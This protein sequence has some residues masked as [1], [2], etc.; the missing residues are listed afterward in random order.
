M[1]YIVLIIISICLLCLYIW[2][3]R[4]YGV[5]CQV[6]CARSSHKATTVTGG[7]FIFYLAAMTACIVMPSDYTWLACALTVAAVVSFADDMRP[8]PILIRLFAQLTAAWLL[9]CQLH[10]TS[11]WWLAASLIVM[12]VAYMNAYNFMDGINGITT[13]YTAIVLL[14]LMWL[15]GIYHFMDSTIAWI[16]LTALACFALFNVRKRALCFPGDVG[17]ISLAVITFFMII[18]LIKTTGEIW[19]MVL[20]GVYGVDTAL[21]VA[22]RAMLHEKIYMPHR[23]HLYQMLCNESGLPHIAISSLYAAVQ[24]TVNAGAIL[25][26][27]N[28]AVYSITAIAILSIIYICVVRFISR[29]HP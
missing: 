9:A 3:C 25:F 12:A 5:M 27:Y 20:A 13:L 11:P 19:W 8:L 15:N 7:G 14:S 6:A 23:R 24:A 21:T 17:A 10:L 1:M 26:R 2:T 16:I 22:R 28:I 18:S 29:H 4:R